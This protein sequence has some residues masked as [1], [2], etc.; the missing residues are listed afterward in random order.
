MRSPTVRGLTRLTGLT[1]LTTLVCALLLAGGSLVTDVRTTSAAV[2]PCEDPNL[3]PTITGSGVIHGTSGDD[4]IYGS[5]EADQIDGGS[6]NDV[7]CGFGGDD[8]L[9]GDSG[10][11]TVVGG[12]GS[13]V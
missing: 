1:G 12:L 6:G 11:D 2:S 9:D 7:I 3:P 10:N 8:V 13:D 4:V 5:D